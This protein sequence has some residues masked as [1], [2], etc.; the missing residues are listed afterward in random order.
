MHLDLTPATGTL[1][2]VVSGIGDAQLSAATPCRGVTVAG[3]R[4]PGKTT[5]PGRG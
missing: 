2:Q 3:W 1:A 5:R 4:P